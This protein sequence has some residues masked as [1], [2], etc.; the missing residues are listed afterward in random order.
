M[1]DKWLVTHIRKDS[2]GRIENYRCRKVGPNGVPHAGPT[3]FTRHQVAAAILS[4]AEF[5]TAPS[6]GRGGIRQG[7]LIEIALKTHPDAS[8]ADNLEKL[9]TF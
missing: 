3:D 2:K 7:A 6:D 5:Y 1:A 8:A 9:P 4:N